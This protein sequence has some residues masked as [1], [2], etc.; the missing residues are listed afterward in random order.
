MADPT[1]G[2]LTYVVDCG[3]T[4]TKAMVLDAQGN[5][6]CDRMKQRTPYPCPPDALVDT[7]T[8]LAKRTEQPFDRVSVGFPGMVRRGVVLATPHYVNEAGPFTPPRPDLVA[9]WAGHDIRAHIERELDRPTRVLNDAEVAGLGII[10]GRGFEVMLT[11]G[12]GLGCAL[13]DDG[14]LLPKL[15]LSHAPFRKGET[16][17]QQLGHHARK[18]IGKVR[19][20]AR[21][22]QAIEALRPI[23]WWDR[24][25]IGG[26]G[27]KHLVQELGPDVKIVGNEYGLLGGIA[28]W[29]DLAPVDLLKEFP[30]H[31]R[32]ARLRRDTRFASWYATIRS[33]SATRRRRS[34]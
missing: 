23:L 5:P 12:T 11:L 6:L 33:R 4:G 20:S 7:I 30:G 18:R 1:A 22:Q 27:T 3:G 28:L 31:D 2:P 19:W 16:F 32:P 24:L 9:A 15:E 34:R 8:M 29:Q 13:F 17:D 25:Y 21:V 14:R 10:E 26:G